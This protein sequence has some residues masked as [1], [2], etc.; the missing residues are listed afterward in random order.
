M[1]T[2]RELAE[3]LAHRKGYEDFCTPGAMFFEPGSPPSNDSIAY[4]RYTQIHRKAE[5]NLIKHLRSGGLVAVVI[6]RPLDPAAAPRPIP[7]NLWGPGFL[8]IDFDTSTVTGAG[9]DQAKV[10]VIMPS[11]SEVIPSEKDS[12]HQ[13]EDKPRIMLRHYSHE[14]VYDG[15]V[16]HFSG[17]AHW[18]CISVMFEAYSNG[19][20]L[21]TRDLLL[22][23]NTKCTSK[24]TLFSKNV[25][26]VKLKDRGIVRLEAGKCYFAA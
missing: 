4:Q 2:A 18:Q 5:E 13:T 21:Y 25:S 3:L 14:V 20:Q 17:T 8:Q 19:Q 6:E 24:D 15:E 9:L 12:R 11:D 22:K 23:V 16:Y 10:L 26:W 1:L 7:T